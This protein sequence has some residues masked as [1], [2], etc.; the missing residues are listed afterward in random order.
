MVIKTKNKKWLGLIAHACNLSYFKG[1]DQESND[2]RPG[3]AKSYWDPILT[4]KLYVLAY[5]YHSSY[6]GDINGK[7]AIQSYMGTNAR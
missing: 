6:V 2:S 1:Q 4:K 7:I 5:A 3:Q